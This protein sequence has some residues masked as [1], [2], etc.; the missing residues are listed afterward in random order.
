M[1][2]WSDI[3]NGSTVEFGSGGYAFMLAVAFIES[4]A[5]VGLIVPSSALFI[6]AG[7]VAGLGLF[8]IIPLITAVALG[9]FLGDTASYLLGAKGAGW[10]KPTNTLFKLEYVVRGEK[11]FA[12]HGAKSVFLARFISPLRPIIPFVAG[13]SRMKMRRFVAYNS[14]SAILSSAVYVGAGFVVGK[15]SDQLRPSIGS[16][17]LFIAVIVSAITAVIVFRFFLIKKGQE[18]TAAILIFA[19]KIVEHGLSMVRLGSWV[20]PNTR[21]ERVAAALL[22]AFGTVGIAVINSLALSGWTSDVYFHL[23]PIAKLDALVENVIPLYRTAPITIF[24]KIITFLGSPV[25]LGGV[26]LGFSA[27]LARAKRYREAFVALTIIFLTGVNVLALKH[28]VARERP[29]LTVAVITETGKS[30]PS[31]HASLPMIVLGLY[32]Y[33]IR[34]EL[35]CWVHKVDSFLIIGFLILIIGAS[36]IYLGVHFPSDILG[37]F[38]LA[39]SWLMIGAGLERLVR[40]RPETSSP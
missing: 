28:L 14:L 1:I 22:I 36:R 20:A 16:L 19:K 21:P 37:G 17:E 13:L 33:I 34:P 26:A 9:G 29:S 38:T 23:S 5:F 2:S 12:E 25:F 31:G 35:P 24:F 40:S 3:I 7:F 30:F 15:V 11:Y 8:H 6:G 39:F 4:I 27:W 32:W 18:I 10:F